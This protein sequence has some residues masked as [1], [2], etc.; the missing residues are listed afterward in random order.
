MCGPREDMRGR[1][2]GL[3][4]DMC[5]LRACLSPSLC[6]SFFCSGR[7]FGGKEGVWVLG[8]GAPHLG[9]GVEVGIDFLKQSLECPIGGAGRQ[10]GPPCSF[11][12]PKLLLCPGGGCSPEWPGE[13]QAG[14]A[15]VH[16]S[17]ICLGPGGLS[18]GL[19]YADSVTSV[20]PPRGL[21]RLAKTQEYPAP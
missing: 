8:R 6:A 10:D 16:V 7:N 9:V 3:A 15:S 2:P 19:P 13:P 1:S 21:R 14:V 11:W 20:W 4:R 5:G 17:S 18:R 12:H